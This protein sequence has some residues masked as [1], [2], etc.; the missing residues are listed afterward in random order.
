MTDPPHNTSFC[1]DR[2]EDW[3]RIPECPIPQF[4]GGEP[5]VCILLLLSLSSGHQTSAAA[6]KNIHLLISPDLEVG[7]RSD[8]SLHL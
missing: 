6:T 1:K 3:G 2:P 5:G 7:D 8:G 4:A